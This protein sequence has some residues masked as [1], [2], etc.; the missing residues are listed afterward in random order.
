MSIKQNQWENPAGTRGFGFIEFSAPEPEEL[1]SLFDRMGLPEVAKHKQKAI[2][3]HQQNNIYFL[4]NSEKS[5]FV[6]DFTSAHGPCVCSYSF[7]VENAVE[8]YQLA[9]SKGAKAVKESEDALALPVV[10]GVGG[11]RLYFQDAAMFSALL[12]SEFDYFVEPVAID[13]EGALHFIDH[14][15]HNVA[16][17]GMDYWSRFYGDIFNF[18][19][20]RY[21]NIEGKKTGLVSRALTSPCG[22]IRI[23]INESSDD[24][25]QIAEFLEQ[26]H[27][28]GVQHI[29]LCSTDL[30]RTVDNL[31]RN[32]LVFQDTI[33]AYYDLVDKRLPNHGEDVEALRGRKI[34]IDG[35]DDEGLLLQIFSGNVIGPIFFEFIQRKGNKGFGEGNFQALFES[36]ELDQIR[37][38]V[39]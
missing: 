19:E 21:F 37:R 11:A 8:A 18:R 30:Y 15:T 24:K 3:I 20:I 6:S 36:I 26:Y 31:K 33:D 1:K 39:I 23:P 35:G 34:L 13:S 10:E 4:I 28:D 12:R 7:E 9:L 22:N 16:V 27:G 29:A 25:S 38:G 2:S 17:G 32:G 14:I 5:G